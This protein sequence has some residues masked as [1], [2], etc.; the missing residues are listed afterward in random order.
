MLLHRLFVFLEECFESLAWQARELPSYAMR[1]CWVLVVKPSSS[2][3][4][5]SRN[6][7]EFD[8]MILKLLNILGFN[9][10]RIL[11]CL[12]DKQRE[13]R[14]ELNDKNAQNF[15]CQSASKVQRNVRDWIVNENAKKASGLHPGSA[16]RTRRPPSTAK[17]L[18]TKK[19]RSFFYHST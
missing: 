17:F 9:G 14:L 13:L 15:Q 16:N 7:F 1:R 5:R 11:V 4:P 2:A 12:C 10:A 3:K 6:R 8:M 19:S 18:A